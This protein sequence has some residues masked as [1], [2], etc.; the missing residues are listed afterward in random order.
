MATYSFWC[1]GLLWCS[2]LWS[3]SSLLD[4]SFLWCGFLLSSD[5]LWCSSL[6]LSS[7]L[8]CSLLGC[9]G[10]LCCSWSFLGG[11][12]SLLWGSGLLLSGGLRCSSLLCEL[13][14][15]WWTCLRLVRLCCAYIEVGGNVWALPFGCSKRP[16][17]TPAFNDRLKR[18]SNC[19]PVAMSLLLAWTYFLM[20]DLLDPLRSFKV[21]MASV[22][23]STLTRQRLFATYNWSLKK[24]WQCNAI[25]TFVTRLRQIVVV[26]EEMQTHQHSSNVRQRSSTW[27]QKPL[28]RFWQTFYESRF[29]FEKVIL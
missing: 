26:V 22:I 13:S 25:A 6:L 7:W 12:S 3:S 14:G 24:L 8:S 29:G 21:V 11:G 9:G 19:A 4:G 2:L 1:S 20:A 15:S 10:L 18:E 5:L 28:L 23:M 16:L 17:V 27:W